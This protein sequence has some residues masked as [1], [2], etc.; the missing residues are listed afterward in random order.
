MSESAKSKPPISE[1]TKQKL[2]SSLMG[3]KVTEETRKKM[4]EN[5]KGV[6]KKTRSEEHSKNASGAQR[7]RWAKWHKEKELKNEH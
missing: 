2:S 7:L 1:E 5:R 4:S 3:H 6:K